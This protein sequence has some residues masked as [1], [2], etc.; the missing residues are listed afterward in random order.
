MNT[1]PITPCPNTCIRVRLFPAPAP[2]K[3]A[4]A[5]VE[6]AALAEVRKA[7]NILAYG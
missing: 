1:A 2:S 6:A 4:R 7:L 5:L 3:A